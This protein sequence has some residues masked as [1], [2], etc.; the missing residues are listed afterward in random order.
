MVLYLCEKTWLFTLWS[1]VQHD[2]LLKKMCVLK[3][4]K[5]LKNRTTECSW[6]TL[7]SLGKCSHFTQAFLQQEP[8]VSVFDTSL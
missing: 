4:K 3:L 8:E 5:W 2:M 1:L 6:L 7:N